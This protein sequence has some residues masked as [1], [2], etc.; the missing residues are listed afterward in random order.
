MFDCR[1]KEIAANLLNNFQEIHVE[2]L[3][4]VDPRTLQPVGDS[5]ESIQACAAVH[6]EGVR[7]IDNMRVK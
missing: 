5:A 2:Y 1:Q 3:E 7:L 4:L 6:V